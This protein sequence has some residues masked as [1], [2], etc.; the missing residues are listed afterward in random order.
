[1]YPFTVISGDL[2][3]EFV[4][5][6]AILGAVRQ[7]SWFLGK[8]ASTRR[9]RERLITLRVIAAAC[10]LWTHCA[11]SPAA[12]EMDY[13]PDRGHWWSS[14]EEKQLL[15]REKYLWHSNNPLDYLLVL[16]AS[17]NYH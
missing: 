13:H 12:M 3:G 2:L 7:E 14:L 6:L 17:F 1:M 4:F 5:S 10:S 11:S 8:D 16:H 9:H 15:Y